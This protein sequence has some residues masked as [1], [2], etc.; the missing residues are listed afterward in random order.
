MERPVALA[1]GKVTSDYKTRELVAVNVT[2][3]APR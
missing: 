3:Y 1:A 2:Q